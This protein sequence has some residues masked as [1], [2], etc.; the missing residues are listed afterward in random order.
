MKRTIRIKQELPYKPEQVWL[1]LTDSKLLGKWFMENDIKPIANHEFTFHMA[2]QK[3]WDGITYCK[4]IE[5]EQEKYISYTYQG[6]ASG[7]KTL[8]CAGIH[9]DVA[10][11][12]AK[13]IF[14]K[15]NTVLSFKLI[16]NSG[17]TILELEHSGF[18]GLK[19]VIVSFVMG[20]GWKKQVEKKLPN[21]LEKMGKEISVIGK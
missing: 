10:D 17:G 3:G 9:S 7:E 12:A 8:S 18:S 6:E 19:L 11:K 1:A 20:M 15:L 4:V 2:P 5:V 14:T 21:L 13:G 16:P